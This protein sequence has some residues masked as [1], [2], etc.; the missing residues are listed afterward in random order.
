MQI[1]GRITRQSCQSN[2]HDISCFSPYACDIMK[3]PR[4][5]PAREGIEGTIGYQDPGRDK[6]DQ[7]I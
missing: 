4:A 6:L 5:D 7:S 1:F 3:R 2:A